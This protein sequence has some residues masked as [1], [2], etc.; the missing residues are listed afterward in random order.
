MFAEVGFPHLLGSGMF[1]S[2]I[3]FECG[4]IFT[5]VTHDRAY[6]VARFLKWQMHFRYKMKL[7]LFLNENL[8]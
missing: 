1:S 4:L 2:L 8:P 5:D 7:K 3:W 6:K